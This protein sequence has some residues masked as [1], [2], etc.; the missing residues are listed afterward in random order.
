[1]DELDRPIRHLSFFEA[2]ASLDEQDAEWRAT[3]AGLVVLRL[4]DA[5]L[6]EGAHVASADAWGLS[7]VREAVDGMSPGDPARTILGGVVDAMAGAPRNDFALVAA[8]LM[9]YGRAL[10][11]DAKWRLAADVYETLVANAHPI[12]EADVYIDAS[13]QLG[14]CSRMVGAWDRAAAA[15]AEAGRVATSVG[16]VVGILRARIADAR[17]SMSRG[18]LPRAEAILD[19]TIE[20]A[21]AEALDDVAGLALNERAA[22][23]HERREYEQ[24]IRFAYEAL[25]RVTGQATRD[26]VLAD[27]AASFMELGVTSVARDA[28]LVLAATAQEQ[29]VRWTSTLN[30]FDIAIR[31]GSEP[32]FELY[33]RQLARDELPIALRAH[34]HIIAGKGYGAFSRPVQARRELDQAIELSASHRLNQLLFTAEESLRQLE[35]GIAAQSI[36][37][38]KTEIPEVVADVAEAIR[39]MKAAVGAGGG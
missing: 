28:F 13:M 7:A 9:A 29:Y 8:P 4:V 12:D 1:M 6:D 27:I 23:A 16:D 33:R 38:A 25:S 15:Y 10:N 17:L 36:R 30:L 3:T 14:Y 31:E 39:G 18:N 2:L 37:A 32:G 34:Y 5:W 26:R 20:R 35:N 22:L 21:K 11:F 24:S 19:D